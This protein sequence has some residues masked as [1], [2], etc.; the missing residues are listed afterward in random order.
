MQE[1]AKSTF[2]AYDTD[3]DGKL[4]LSEYDRGGVRTAF[5]GFVRGHSA[6]VDGD[7]NHTITEQELLDFAA[8]LFTKADRNR[9]GK[10]DET[11]ASMSGPGGRKP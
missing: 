8:E 1:Q 7:G 11:E 6:E 3:K 5:A 10:T 9:D 2:A 4:V